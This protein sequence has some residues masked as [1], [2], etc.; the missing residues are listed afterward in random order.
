MRDSFYYVLIHLTPLC[1]ICIFLLI[2]CSVL[3]H[4]S[5]FFCIKNSNALNVLVL[6]NCILT[7][8]V[9]L[10]IIIK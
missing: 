6:K 5:M 9:F 10:T 8:K 2:M 3:S 1:A 4:I 7:I